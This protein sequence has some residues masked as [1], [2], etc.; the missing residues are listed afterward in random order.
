MASEPTTG[1][2]LGKFMPPH[3]GHLYLAEFAMN[4]VDRLIVLVCTLDREPI[5]GEL[6]YRW[7]RECLP[8]ATV[9][10]VTDDVPQTP[11][12]HPDFW[13]IWA[14]LV[15][16]HS[17]FTPGF[18]FASEDYGT[19]LADVLD[20]RYIPVDPARVSLRASGT[21]VRSEPFAMWGVLP[22]PVR[23]HFARRVSVF[24]PESTGKSTLSE[25][26]ARHFDTVHVPEWARPFLDL[27]GGRCDREDIP[28][29][30]RGQCA[31]EDAL[32]RR[33]NRI[34]ICDT[35]PLLTTIWS[36]VLFGECPDAVTQ[37]ADARHYDLTLLLDVDVPWVDDDQR[38]LAAPDERRAFFDRCERALAGRGRRCVKI[39]GGWEARFGRAVE[40]IESL[41]P[42]SGS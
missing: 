16:R 12:E 27:K 7:M 20:A 28:L 38:F 5:P 34:L 15:R 18:V 36:D 41:V 29:I 10:H 40:A 31:S 32:A 17:P 9:V 11:D 21:A 25:L 37:C 33:C 24:G 22:P 8:D 19:P 26:L 1:L 3:A 39:D 4:F 35:D 30:A 6:R 42:P 2:I 14:D 13:P 23:A